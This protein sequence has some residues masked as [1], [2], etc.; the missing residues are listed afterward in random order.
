M[1]QYKEYLDVTAEKE[2]MQA[3]YN[4]MYVL[5]HGCEYKRKKKIFENLLTKKKK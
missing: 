1:I 3:A 5:C 2:Q 4:K